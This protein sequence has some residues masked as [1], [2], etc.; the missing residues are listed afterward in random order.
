MSQMQ[1]DVPVSLP[2]ISR[3]L[4]PDVQE[5]PRTEALQHI[6]ALP[7]YQPDYDYRPDRFRYTETHTT[8]PDY[9]VLGVGMMSP[10][11]EHGEAL[12]RMRNALHIL[13]QP[14]ASE[15]HVSREVSIIGI[16]GTFFAS[17][18]HTSTLQPG[19]SLWTGPP[20]NSPLSSYRYD[21][22]RVPLLVVEVVSHSDPAQR[23]NDWKTRCLPTP[24]WGS[25]NIGLWTSNCQT[26]SGDSR[27][28]P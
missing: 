1:S 21:R 27:W 19:L 12:D 23:D 25:G 13:I 6:R 2:S 7:H 11:R 4:R 20:P 22:D 10:T 28:M 3:R 16:P 18:R 26:P 17:A 5:R 9:V 8:D 15:V 14:F 24:A